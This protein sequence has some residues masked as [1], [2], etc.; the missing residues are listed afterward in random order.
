MTDFDTRARTWDTDP[1]K[2]ERA[3]RIAEAIAERVPGLRRMSV[4]EYGCGTG[5]LGLALLP[6]AARVTLADSSREMIAVAREKIAAS[7]AA[8]V[9]A[10]R[11]DLTSEPAPAEKYDLV[12]TLL[13]LHHVGD[14][15][16]VLRKLGEVLPSGGILCVADLDAEDGSFHGAGF[17]GHQGFDR[18][19]LGRRLERAGFANVRFQTVFE[20]AKDTGAGTRR[21]P[22]FLA[23]ADRR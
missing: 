4:L 8:N 3:R 20:I 1:A 14:V 2:V 19:D 10:I 16:G 21:F 5:L 7:G 11:L 15:D 12:C 18:A 22:V 6:R 23:L 17:D 9:S 13:T